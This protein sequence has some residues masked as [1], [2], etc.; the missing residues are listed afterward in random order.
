MRQDQEGTGEQDLH[1]H[2]DVPCGSLV[3]VVPV[4]TTHPL[5]KFCRPARSNDVGNPG[6]E[7]RV[8]HLDLLRSRADETVPLL[9]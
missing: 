5:W 6:N 1:T 4:T 7:L 3:T 8:G 2:G 9:F